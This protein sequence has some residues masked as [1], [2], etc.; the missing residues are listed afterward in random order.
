MQQ[1]DPD[2]TA[3]LPNDGNQAALYYWER[4]YFQTLKAVMACRHSSKHAAVQLI[5]V[6]LQAGKVWEEQEGNCWMDQDA[7]QSRAPRPLFTQ[8]RTRTDCQ[9]RS[10]PEFVD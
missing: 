1:N 5:S 2:Q 3:L 7:D 4:E 8:A 9:E 6:G 10:R